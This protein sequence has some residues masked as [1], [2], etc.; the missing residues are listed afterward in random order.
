MKKLNNK[1]TRYRVSLVTGE[2]PRRGYIWDKVHMNL[3][4]EQLPNKD[5]EELP[6]L[7]TNYHFLS[8]GDK[9]YAVSIIKDFFTLE[10]LYEIIPYFANFPKTTMIITK[11]ELP[12]EYKEGFGSDAIPVGGLEDF[13]MFT[14]DKDY[15]LSCRVWGY[16]DLTHPETIFYKDKPEQ[17]VKNEK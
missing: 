17:G 6:L 12:I 13:Y 4:K 1:Q 15:P 5:E 2:F 10:E 3:F 14:D 8:E 9:A 16:F 11:V 7:V